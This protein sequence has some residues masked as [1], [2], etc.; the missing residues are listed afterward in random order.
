MQKIQVLL[1]TQ[2]V[3]K[4]YAR[5]LFLF[6]DEHPFFSITSVFGIF[7]EVSQWLGRRRRKLEVGTEYFYQ[8]HKTVPEDLSRWS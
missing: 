8:P 1:G 6:Q 3:K 4:L 2:K 5:P 7:R